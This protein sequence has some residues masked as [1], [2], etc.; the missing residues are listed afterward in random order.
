MRELTLTEKSQA[1]LMGFLGYFLSQ[2]EGKIFLRALL[3]RIK[4]YLNSHSVILILI[5]NK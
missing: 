2:N 4:I 3:Q 5:Q 1:F